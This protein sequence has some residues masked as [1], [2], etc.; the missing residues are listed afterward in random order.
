MRSPSR[1]P[2]KR[3]AYACATV[4]HAWGPS[5]LLFVPR[6]CLDD[7]DARRPGYASKLISQLKPI[8]MFSGE[9]RNDDVQGGLLRG[10]PRPAVAQSQAVESTGAARPARTVNGRDSV[11]GLASLQL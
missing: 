7:G 4:A 8:A 11:Q 1:G 2:N 10:Q 9:V 6:C 3:E 5:V